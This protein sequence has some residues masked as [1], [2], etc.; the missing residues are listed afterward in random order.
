MSMTLICV[1]GLCFYSPA[2]E[3][4]VRVVKTVTIVAPCVEPPLPLVACEPSNE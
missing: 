4:P 2:P 3:V 1:V